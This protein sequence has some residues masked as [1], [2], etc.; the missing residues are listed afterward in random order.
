[1]V[2]TARLV[3][4]P[5]FVMVAIV[6]LEEAHVPFVEGVTFAVR[7]K[8]ISEGP[9]RTGAP[10]TEFMVTFPDDKDVQLLRFVTVKL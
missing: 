3:T 4:R 6:L 1:M 9:P 8:H 10:G 7:P 5:E 2:P